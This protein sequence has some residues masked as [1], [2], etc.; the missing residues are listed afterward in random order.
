MAQVAYTPIP[1]VSA[2]GPVQNLQMNVR[3]NPADFGGLVGEAEQRAASQ[4]GQGG[5]EMM[6]AGMYRRDLTNEIWAN[7]ANTA[8]MK[9]MTDAWSDYNKLEGRAAQDALPK[10]QDQVNSI[11]SDALSKAPS[12]QTQAM[13]SRTTRQ[14]ADWYLKSGQNYADQQWKTWQ[15]KSALDGSKAFYSQAALAVN[16]PKAMDTFLNSG[17]D[18]I[19]K[20]G[21]QKGYDKQTTDVMVSQGRGAA[22]KDIVA[23]KVLDGDATGAKAILDKYS[24]QMDA[25]SRLE[26]NRVIHGHLRAIDAQKEADDTLSKLGLGGATSQTSQAPAGTASPGQPATAASSASNQPASG[27]PAGN[28]AA[29]L[30]QHFEGFISTPKWDVNAYRI[31]YGSDTITKADGSVEKVTQGMSVTR[32]DAQRDLARRAADFAKTAAGQVGQQQ[33]SALPASAQAALTSVAYNYGHLPAG[34]VAAV[35]TGDVQQIA[36][37]VEAHAGDNGGINAQRRKQEANIIR[38]NGQIPATGSSPDTSAPGN[39]F[40]NQPGS[41]PSEPGV[42]GSPIGGI[43][44]PVASASSGAPNVTQTHEQKADIYQ[45]KA[46]AISAIRTKYANDPEMADAII[47]RVNQGVTVSMLNQKAAQEQALAAQDTAFNKYYTA[48]MKGDVPPSQLTQMIAN[49]N[50][51]TGQTKEHLNNAIQTIGQGKALGSSFYSY[52]QRIHSNGTD[53]ITSPDQILQAVDGSSL[54]FDGANKLREEL[55]G[56]KTIDADAT[57]EMKK[58]ALAYIKHNLSFEADYGTFKIPD[59]AGED[60]FNSRAIPAFYSALDA[61]QKAGKTPYQLLTAGSPDYIGDKII[62]TFKRT[63]AQEMKDKIAAGDNSMGSTP[64]ATPSS[65]PPATSFDLTAPT[66]VVAAYK[67]GSISR[68]DANNR[69]NAFRA[70]AGQANAP[71]VPNN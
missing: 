8:A 7:D 16:D 63:P 19:R 44:A 22:V 59:P 37:A 50:S 14:M 68:V 70:A 34:V 47:A 46:D 6:Q 58:G 45:D 41:N 39:A 10:F 18:Q 4:I 31:G 13:L 69:L 27:A 33:W 49:D 57:A 56:A 51:L 1:E 32:E 15:D 64:T 66:G 67:A 35:K 17:D 60:I 11:Y 52:F 71:Q 55:N 26:A 53:K 36:S 12:L 5:Q 2:N 25:A 38:G 62:S 40:G 24:D 9:Q 42:P 61:G 28:G 48:A 29:A 21:E 3:A 23:Q 43:P 20:L 65:V 54:T 30:L